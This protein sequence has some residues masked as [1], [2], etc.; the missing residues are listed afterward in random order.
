MP[1]RIGFQLLGDA[2]L[3]AFLVKYFFD[4]FFWIF[5]RRM[6]APFFLGVS[7]VTPTSYIKRGT[8]Q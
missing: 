7:G 2:V 4:R 5:L 3:T 6:V 1:P 8:G